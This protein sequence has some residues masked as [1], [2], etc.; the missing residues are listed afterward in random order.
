MECICL[1]STYKCGFYKGKGDLVTCSKEKN[2][3]TFYAVLGGLGQFGVKWLHLLYNNFTAFSGD[4]EHL[5]SFSERNE[6]IAADYVEGMLLLNQ[7]PLDLSFYAASGQ[8]RITT[9]VTQYGIVYILELVK[10]YDNNSQAHIN[11]DLVNL[12]KGL[13]FVPTFMLEKDASYEEFL[14][15]VHVAELVLRSKGLSKIPHP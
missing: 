8:Q 3:D 4:Q 1:F 7:P 12:V 15:R 6:I 5:I 11:E 10:Y 2:S 14:N 13:N 9:L